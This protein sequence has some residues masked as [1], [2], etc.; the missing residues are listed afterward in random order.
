MAKLMN[1]PQILAGIRN[2]MSKQEAQGK[3]SLHRLLLLLIYSHI[4]NFHGG[5]CK[6]RV[7]VAP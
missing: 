1:I 6:S 2:L 5:L 3:P 4:V 7:D